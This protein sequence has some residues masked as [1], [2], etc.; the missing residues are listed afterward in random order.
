MLIVARKGVTLFIFL[1]DMVAL[2][3]WLWLL[4]IPL[5]T[6]LHL[7]FATAKLD[8]THYAVAKL[9]EWVEIFAGLALVYVVVREAIASMDTLLTLETLR[10]FGLSAVLSVAF[11][12][13]I[14][15]LTVYEPYERIFGILPFHIPDARLRRAA[16]WRAILT[17]RTDTDFLERWRRI[18]TTEPP[19]NI[20]EIKVSFAKLRTIKKMERN[21]QVVA[22]QNGWLPQ[23]AIRF[24]EA[25]GLSTNDYHEAAYEPD[26]WWTA[27]RLTQSGQGSFPNNIAYY[28][29]GTAEIV[30][31]LKLKLNVNNPETDKASRAL[32][33]EHALILAGEALNKAWQE[34][35]A[36]LLEEATPF[37]ILENG[38]RV[39]L[40]RNDWQGGI[41]EGYDLTFEILSFATP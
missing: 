36:P 8:P 23:S 10:L 41:P 31:R 5:I 32:L 30:S 22:E 27:S 24:L 29:Y 21:P 39:T 4:I 15:A 34:R 40:V 13:F 20:D 33:S 9:L 25:E 2:S 14:A 17:F 19:T 7:L 16:R 26:E 12:P 1:T 3:L 28:V 6:V 35:L 11:L 38:A 37:D 18:I